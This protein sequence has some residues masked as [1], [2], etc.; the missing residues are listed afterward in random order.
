MK[1]L[2]AGGGI[3]GLALALS[4]HQKGIACEVFERSSEIRELGV[5]I[6]TLP[7]AI[8]ELADLG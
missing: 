3:G 7:H 5:G 4:L 6:N 8:K 1:V 2:I